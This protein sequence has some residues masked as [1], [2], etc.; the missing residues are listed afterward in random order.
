MGIVTG[1]A[2]IDK[3]MDSV[4]NFEDGPKANWVKIDPGKSVKISFLQELDSDSDFYDPKAG[5]VLFALEH[6]NPDNFRR[7]ALCTADEGEPC[8]A[9][10]QEKVDKRWKRRGRMYAN[11]LVDN[12]SGNPE[13][14]I[15][16]QGLSGKSITPALVMIAKD[17]GTITQMQFRVARKG[18]GTDTEYT[19]IPIMNSS[20]VD[21]SQYL[22]SMY[23]LSA[24]CTREIEYAEQPKFYLGDTSDDSDSESAENSATH[25]E[26]V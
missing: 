26:W 24:V 25:T 14:G 18:S 12:G 5:A 19:V 15:L 13:V 16:S 8:W 2:Q 22:D 21:V 1:L 3:L 20:G 10:E 9:C 4:G 11:V 6:S 17:S 23:D 7:K